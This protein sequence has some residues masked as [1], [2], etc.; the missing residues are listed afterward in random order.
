MKSCLTGFFIALCFTTT[1][2]VRG[3]IQKRWNTVTGEPNIRVPRDQ[4][5]GNT[6]D[7]TPPGFNML[8]MKNV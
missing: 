1:K 7:E 4:C 2:K 6:E 8:N 3:L 5:T